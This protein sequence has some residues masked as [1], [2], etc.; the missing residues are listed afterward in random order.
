MANNLIDGN[1]DVGGS[2]NVG[3]NTTVGGTL[4]VN[5]VISPKWNVNQLLNMHSD[6]PAPV[7]FTTGGG[8]LIIFASGSGFRQD[9][10]GLVGMNITVDGTL[11]GDAKVYTNEYWSHKAFTTNALVV[12]N[13]QAGSHTLQLEAM[14]DTIIDYNDYFSVT[15]LELPF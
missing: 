9:T 14:S 7:T 2:L 4:E 11:Y 12:N 3:G 13:L 1:L 15:V 6:L 5:G 10:E 8:T